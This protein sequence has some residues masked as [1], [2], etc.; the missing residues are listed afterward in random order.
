MG[1]DRILLCVCALLLMEGTYAATYDME[2]CDYAGFLDVPE[3]APVVVNGGVLTTTPVPNPCSI[4]FRATNP[5][6]IL[7]IDITIL[8][9]IDCSITLNFIYGSDVE[10]FRCGTR[11]PGKIYT[12]MRQITV[13][14]LRGPQVSSYKFQFLLTSTKP[15]P[16]YTW[17]QLQSII[18]L[19]LSWGLCLVSSSLLLVVAILK[20]KNKKKGNK[21]DMKLEDYEPTSGNFQKNTA[22]ASKRAQKSPRLGNRSDGFG[23]RRRKSEGRSDG[24]YEDSRDQEHRP[25]C[26]TW[27]HCLLSL[28][29]ASRQSLYA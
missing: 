7:T 5:E 27:S 2:K 6:H 1:W 15:V 29:S 23:H 9:L 16:D 21:K 10:T 12:N 8:N 22:R 4:V 20:I 14:F 11:N 3:G 17:G 19:A 28:R 26:V 25:A 13:N 18:R 24:E